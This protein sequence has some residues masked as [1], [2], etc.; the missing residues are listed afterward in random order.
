MVT[1]YLFGSELAFCITE[2]ELEVRVCELGAAL[3]S[4]KF[5]GQECVLGYDSPKGY[6]ETAV[7]MG[8]IVG[9]YANRI[10]RGEAVIGGKTYQLD[11]NDGRNHL[12]GGNPGFHRRHWK[13]EKAGESAVRFTLYSPAGEGGYPANVEAAVTYAVENGR[14]RLTLE[15][16]ADAETL[17]APTTH[18]YFNFTGKPS[19]LGSELAIFADCHLPVDGELIPTGELAPVAGSRYDFRE[20]RPV[21][22]YYD[23]AFVLRGEHACTMRAN[24]ME[25]EIRTDYP[26]LQIYSGEGLT[27]PFVAGGGIALEPELY[28]DS[29]HHADWP[30][31]T[32]HAGET[33]RKYVEYRFRKL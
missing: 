24:G 8:L 27:E 25:M 7:C 14:V 33:F 11:C 22:G 30:Q 2:G 13:G 32:L 15:G 3:L 18:A 21:E 31:A 26:A 4:M 12:H 6:E 20:L 9:R 19:A 23:D 10:A 28:P 29:P 1:P 16:T 5:A 17:F